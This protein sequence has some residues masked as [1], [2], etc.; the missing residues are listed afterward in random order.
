MQPQDDQPPPVIE[1]ENA[2]QTQSAS[3]GSTAANV[4]SIRN[5]NVRGIAC[6]KGART[7]IRSAKGRLTMKFNFALR[8]ATCD[9]AEAFNNEIGYIVR[10]DCSLRYKD[11]RFVT[12][13]VR[14]PFRHK[15]LEQMVKEW[16]LSLPSEG[17]KRNQTGK[18]R[19]GVI[20]YCPEQIFM[21]SHLPKLVETR[22]RNNK[23]TLIPYLCK[24]IAEKLP[25]V[26]DFY[27]DLVH[28]EAA[29]KEMQAINKG[30]ENLVH[31]TTAS[32]NDGAISEIFCMI[33]KNYLGSAE[34]EVR[35]LASLYSGVGR[36]ADALAQYFSEDPARCPFDKVFPDQIE[37]VKHCERR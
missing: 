28:V 17:V 30:I 4:E 20:L 19:V 3:I 1:L 15:L 27:E 21:L 22:A 24:V 32:E 9:N 2:A 14:T 23:Q 12:Q 35:S 26:L 7:A 33:L 6:G 29:T 36:N 34:V 18:W 10:N 25:E 16:L 37:M 11:W 5:S 8:L 13:E 31:E